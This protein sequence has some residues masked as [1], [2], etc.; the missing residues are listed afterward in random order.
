MLRWSDCWSL[1]WKTIYTSQLHARKFSASGNL[2]SVWCTDKNVTLHIKMLVADLVLIQRSSESSFNTVTSSGLI[3]FASPPHPGNGSRMTT[4][5]RLPWTKWLKHH[6]K[7][8]AEVIGQPAV[9]AEGAHPRN[10]HPRKCQEHLAWT[11]FLLSTDTSPR[12]NTKAIPDGLCKQL[13]RYHHLQESRRT[14]I[15]KG[16][17]IP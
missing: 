8:S 6:W 11:S 16:P 10:H 3:R 7:V 1:M 9:S 13:G 15:S 12:K 2:D 14:G 4:D 5:R 17:R